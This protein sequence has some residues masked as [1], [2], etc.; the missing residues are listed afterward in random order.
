MNK[1]TQAIIIWLGLF[2]QLGNHL[3]YL[4]G[5]YNNWTALS[6]L[7]VLIVLVFGLPRMIK[8]PI[9]N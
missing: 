4:Q 9:N 6:I 5:V 1:K 8:K 2:L 3:L 7:I